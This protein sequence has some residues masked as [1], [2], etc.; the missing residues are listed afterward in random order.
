[1]S[2]PTTNIT[3]VL[4]ETRLFPPPAEFA[5]AAHVPSA[6]GAR[7]AGEVGRDRPGRLLGRAGQV[8]ALDQ[9]VGHRFS[10]G[11][12]AV[13]PVVRRRAAQRQRQL[14]RPAPRDRRK[15]KAAIIWE[16]EPGDTRTLTYQQLHRE[17]CKFA[18][19]LKLARHREGRPG[20]HLHA[21][22]AGGGDRHA[23]LRPHRRDALRRLRRVL[24][25]RPWPTA[26]TTPRSKL[27]ITADGGWRRGKVVPLKANVDAALDKSPTVEKCIVLN[28]C[29]TPVDDEARPRR[30][31]ARADGDCESDDCPAEPLDS[32]APAVHPVHVR[33]HRQAEGRA[34]HHR[35]L[36]ARRVAHAQ[37]GLRHQ[38]GRRLLVYRG[39]RL[40]D[41][42][43]LH[44]LRP[45]R[46]RRRRW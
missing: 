3:S 31:V 32:R 19:A 16:G 9:A 33:Q 26:T 1:M 6:G 39:R 28:R 29:D 17:V 2:S 44:R 18:N 22:G 12:R 40:G 7:P 41:G 35:R 25:R 21:D 45:A 8:P 15:N 36:P 43:Q 34:A 27:V 24:A 46:Q 14:P 5:A 37:V 13:R 4:K 11:Q 30:V 10:T 42:A 23:R 38:G 20:H